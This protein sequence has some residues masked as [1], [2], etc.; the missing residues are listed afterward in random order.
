MESTKQ[1]AATLAQ[2]QALEDGPLNPLTGNAWP[3]GHRAVLEGRR[4]LPVY[5]RADEILGVLDQHKA[6][7]LTSG[8]GSGKSTQ[9]PQFL[10]YL[11]HM[12]KSGLKIACTQPRRLAATELGA[13]L[14]VEMGVSLGEEVGYRIG[15]QKKY[16][17][18]TR[19]L[20]LTEGV[21]LGMMAIDKELSEYGCIIIDEAHER[22]VQTDLLMGMLKKLLRRRQ[23]LKV[24]THFCFIRY[25]T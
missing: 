4:K 1:T 5:E 12:K 9:I 10:V 2:I 18:T 6:F 11:E 20:Y 22:T 17:K 16:S 15:G 13:R 14:S 24:N 3:E 25:L 8:T 19:L 21:L 23:D 7:V